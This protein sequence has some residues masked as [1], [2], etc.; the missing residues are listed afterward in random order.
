MFRTLAYYLR[1]TL[2][3]HCTYNNHISSM[4]I[5]LTRMSKTLLPYEQLYEASIIV[6]F[7]CRTFI[8][9]CT[10]HNI[11]TV[12]MYKLQFRLNYYMSSLFMQKAFMVKFVT[13]SVSSRTR[14]KRTIEVSVFYKIYR[15]YLR[16]N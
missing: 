15:R 16:L 5:R 12:C 13:C 7:Y 6:T 14:F 9:V 3:I 1:L 10:F 2:L 4:H 11:D 8:L